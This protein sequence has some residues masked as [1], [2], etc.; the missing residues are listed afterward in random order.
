M[1]YYSIQKKLTHMI[2]EAMN[3]REFSGLEGYMAEDM[4]FDFPGPGRIEGRRKVL[5][6][7]KALMRKY[8]SLTFTV[9]DVI[10]EGDRACAVWTNEGTSVE[11]KPYKNSGM[12]LIHFKDGQI[13]FLSDYFK[14]TSFVG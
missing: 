3:S 14:D 13:T 8:A 11:G 6:F 5:I 7:L 12:T 10:I 9:S 1:D 2:F 4:A